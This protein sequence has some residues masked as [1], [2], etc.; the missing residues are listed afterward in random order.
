[1][2]AIINGV[3]VMGTVEEITAIMRTQQ[4]QAQSNYDGQT[5]DNRDRPDF[6]INLK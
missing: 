2:T 1:M 5:C 4:K 6:P 3:T